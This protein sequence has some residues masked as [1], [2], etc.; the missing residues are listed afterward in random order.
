MSY[1]SANFKAKRHQLFPTTKTTIGKQSAS[2]LGALL[3]YSHRADISEHVYL[4]PKL[5]AGYTKIN[6]NAVHESGG[7][8]S[9]LHILPGTNDYFTVAPTLE[10]GTRFKVGS[11]TI[12]PSLALGYSGYYGDG[13]IKAKFAGAPQAIEGFNINGSNEEHF[14][15]TAI[16]IDILFPST[17]SI[18][19]GYSG[20]YSGSTNAQTF[21]LGA[22]YSF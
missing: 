4:E 17:F 8:G 15:T 19:L 5:D 12:A 3:A 2:A 10:A 9:R 16:N 22:K 20:D 21:S 7:G 14:L 18:Q 13:T 1:S 6:R 11:T